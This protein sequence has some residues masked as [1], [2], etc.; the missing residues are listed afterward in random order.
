MSLEAFLLV[1]SVGEASVKCKAC[2]RDVAPGAPYV[3][4]AW[5]KHLREDA[6]CTRKGVEIV[7]A[8]KLSLS[9]FELQHPWARQQ[10]KQK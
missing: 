3:S 10:V 7:E 2:R 4:R 9:V 8:G 1:E 6:A 5:T